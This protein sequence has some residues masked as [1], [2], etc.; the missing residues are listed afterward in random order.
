MRAPPIAD[1]S[2]NRSSEVSPMS[3]AELANT[4][5][6]D[7]FW[8]NIE[9]WAFALVAF[10]LAIEFVA[11]W[12]DKPYAKKLSDAKQIELESIRKEN[13]QLSLQLEGEQ[14]VSAIAG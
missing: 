10:P 4:E 7:K 14:C 12:A 11:H 5:W 13:L 6:W 9:F 1:E 3:A 8:T 2:N